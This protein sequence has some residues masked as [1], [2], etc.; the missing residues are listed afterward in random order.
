MAPAPQLEAWR[1]SLTYLDNLTA[2]MALR[3]LFPARERHISCHVSAKLS[4][5]YRIFHMQ[6]VLM[7]RDM[8]YL[9]WNLLTSKRTKAESAEKI[10]AASFT[11]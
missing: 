5:P 11:R 7:G 3:L 2:P 8:A 4:G 1:T 10:Q 9:S 6:Y